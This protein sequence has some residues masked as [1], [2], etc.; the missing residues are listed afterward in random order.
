MF[1]RQ[2]GDIELG[3]EFLPPFLKLFMKV[4]VGQGLK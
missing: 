3:A 2:S 1:I 4:L